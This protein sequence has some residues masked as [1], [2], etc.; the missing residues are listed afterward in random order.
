MTQLTFEGGST[1]RVVDV[2]DVRVTSPVP[3][4]RIPMSGGAQCILNQPARIYLDQ[5]NGYAAVTPSPD[6]VPLNPNG[7]RNEDSLVVVRA[8]GIFGN[9]P[10]NMG[11]IYTPEDAPTHYATTNAPSW[12]IPPGLRQRTTPPTVEGMT[13]KT[14]ADVL[15]QIGIDCTK[16]GLSVAPVLSADDVSALARAALGKPVKETDRNR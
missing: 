8:A 11:Q 14:H 4:D 6:R 16:S 13:P 7:T 9:Q 2:K 12:T 15:R 10:V 5:Q 1:E 3:H